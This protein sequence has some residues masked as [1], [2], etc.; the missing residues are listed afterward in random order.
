MRWGRRLACTAV[1]A[2]ALTLPAAA[3]PAFMERSDPDYRVLVFTGTAGA[4][5]PAT[6]AGTQAI[7]ELGLDDDF[8]VAATD[9]SAAFTAANLATY[10]VVV[11]LNNSGDV[12]SDAQQ[13]ALEGFVQGGG[14]LV[15][16]H[17]AIEAEP[18][19]QFLTNALGA[20]AT[21]LSGVQQATVKVADHFYLLTYG[22]GFFNANAD[23]QLVKFSYVKHSP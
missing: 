5:H 3:A 20:R 6:D 15:A 2:L 1:A 14:G 7:R 22:D 8:Q 13:A 16:I 21:G 23:A 12:L 9:D 18:A 19:W 17:A 11:L 10:R 4:E